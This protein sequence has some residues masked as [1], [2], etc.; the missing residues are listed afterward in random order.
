VN[1][2]KSMHSLTDQGDDAAW[3]SINEASHVKIVLARHHGRWIQDA[4]DPLDVRK[5]LPLKE[6]EK[7]ALGRFLPTEKGLQQLTA[8][9]K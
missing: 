5:N 3:R 9:A 1:L 4:V 2:A 8:L 6:I 7:Q